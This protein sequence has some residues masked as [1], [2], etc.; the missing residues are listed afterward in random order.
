M[1]DLSAGITIL[2]ATINNGLRH[3]DYERVTALAQEYYDIFTGAG[4]KPYIRQLRKSESDSAFLQA[5]DIYEC[6]IPSVVKSIDV[7]F[8]KPLRSNRVYSSVTD[9]NN[10][11]R[12]EVLDRMESFWQGQLDI[13]VDEYLRERW[14]YLCTYDPNAFI[15]VEF[16]KFDARTQK[17]Q[18]FPMEYTS[19]QAINYEYKRGVLDW[20]IILLPWAY[21]GEGQ[22]MK[23][24]ERY[25]M[26][27]DNQAIVYTEIDY[28]LQITDLDGEIVTFESAQAGAG[29][30]RD[31]AFVRQVFQTKSKRVPAFRAGYELDPETM[32]RTCVSN[33]HYALPFYKNELKI[34]LELDL[35]LREHVFPAKYMYGPKC[36]GDKE[37]GKTCK[38]GV[39]NNGDTCG[40]CRG[41][42]TLPIHTTTQD[43]VVVP[44][45]KKSEEPIMNL[46]E[47]MAYFSPPMDVV[48]FMDTYRDKVIVK[49]KEAVFPAQEV[50]AKTGMK[51]ATEMDYSYDNIYDALYPFTRR[52]SYAWLFIARQIAIYTDNDSDTLQ[53]YHRFPTDLKMKSQETL[54]KEAR[55]AK[56][57][58]LPSHLVKVIHDDL[59][60]VMYADDQDELVKIHIRNKFYPFN[61]KSEG[62]I[63]TILMT[64]EVLPYYRT[65]YIYFDII[66]GQI[67]QQLGDR[68]YIMSYDKQLEEV[69]KRVQNILD[70]VE[71][72]KATAFQQQ[73]QP[74]QDPN[75]PEDESVQ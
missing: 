61:G 69:Q 30:G 47:A 52:Y 35:C 60:N 72:R 20:L 74:I 46:K 40:I 14:Q 21:E 57:S 10:E 13:G 53:L 11:A 27:L 2:D 73:Q 19:E 17:A 70:Q 67:D 31:R 33:Q 15:A 56:D 58:G 3:Q 55:S 38:G 28:Q 59:A 50:I 6:L 51:T 5:L 25:I 4:I 66:F 24:G 64:G 23:D 44:L 9:N 37:A 45:P 29:K 1:N 16:S 71:A 49:A 62:E 48:T 54:L 26:Y 32:K 75:N 36:S 12:Q 68:F 43:V 34:G 63:S 22:T 41:T 39:D 8:A 7:I 65:L 18:P 42:G